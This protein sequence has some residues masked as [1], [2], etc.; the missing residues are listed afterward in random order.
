MRVPPGLD[1]CLGHANRQ[2]P[3]PSAPGTCV[4]FASAHD[5]A[6]AICHAPVLGLSLEASPEEA[7]ASFARIGAIVEA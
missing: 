1:G 2:A 7:L 5:L 3:I 6:L 4:V